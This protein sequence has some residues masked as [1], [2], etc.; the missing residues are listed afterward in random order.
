[1]ELTPQQVHP[2]LRTTAD[3][4]YFR[5]GRAVGYAVRLLDATYGEWGLDG[6]DPWLLTY[7][8]PVVTSPQ[9]YW[10]SICARVKSAC[11]DDAKWRS[12]AAQVSDLPTLHVDTSVGYRQYLHALA[13]YTF[14]VGVTR[15][16]DPELSPREIAKVM[17]VS[18][19]QILSWIGDGCPHWYHSPR[20]YL[21]QRSLVEEWLQ[22][23][24]LA[25]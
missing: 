21:L 4:A 20:R 14:G 3:V 7:G 8:T 11:A 12:A 9:E 6:T 5:L 23:E 16:S 25:A 24:G 13:A 10:P 18:Y 15:E 17:R 22:A 19:G 2:S 1:M